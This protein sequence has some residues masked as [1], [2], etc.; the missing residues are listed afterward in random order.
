MRKNRRAAMA[1]L[2]LVELMI[3]LVISLVLMLGVIQVFIASQTASRLSEGASRVQ[4]NARLRWT[5]WS[6]TSAWPVTWGA[7]MTRRML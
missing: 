5:S 2:S 6:V 7:S 4:E 1:G 3:A